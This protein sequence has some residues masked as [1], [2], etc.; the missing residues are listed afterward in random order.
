MIQPQTNRS[1][2]QE[3]NVVQ[4]TI[5]SLFILVIIL[6][7]LG[8]AQRL[9]EQL[10]TTP[11]LLYSESSPTKT[12]PHPIQRQNQNLKVLKVFSLTGSGTPDLV[13]LPTGLETDQSFT[14]NRTIGHLYPRRVFMRI[15]W[16]KMPIHKLTF[17][18][19]MHPVRPNRPAEN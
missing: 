15:S 10:T 9:G 18:L 8:W 7:G 2:V 19:T 1:K 13:A 6:S 11:G 16:S 14:V 3:L 5:L 4:M 17:Y 12:R